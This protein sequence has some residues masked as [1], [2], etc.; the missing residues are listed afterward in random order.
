MHRIS[1]KVAAASVRSGD[2]VDYGFGIGQ[3]DAF[4]KAL[5]SHLDRRAAILRRFIPFA[6]T[7]SGLQQGETCGRDTVATG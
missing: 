5:P 3:P 2:W 7:V 1:P 6:D 4:D